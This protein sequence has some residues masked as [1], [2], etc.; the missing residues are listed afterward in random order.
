MQCRPGKKNLMYLTGQLITA[1]IFVWLF[2]LSPVASAQSSVLDQL[3]HDL[4]MH[5]LEPTP[6]MALAKFYLDKGDRLQAFYIMESARR[7]RLKDT[8]FNQAFLNTFGHSTDSD[9]DRDHEAP[10]LADYRRRIA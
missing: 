7:G 4:A 3:R 8:I 2:S 1:T 9:N 5:Y 6:H 10:G